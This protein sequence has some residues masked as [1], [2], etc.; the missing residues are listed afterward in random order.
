MPLL[1]TSITFNILQVPFGCVEVL[2][3]LLLDGVSLAFP[4]GLFLRPLVLFLFS[5]AGVLA[6]VL[7]AIKVA[8]RWLLSR[9][10]ANTISLFQVTGTCCT[11]I[12][13]R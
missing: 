8:F 13:A 7:W 10:E 3:S 2:F 1:S 11:F 6:A 5:F 4:S 9:R 12:M